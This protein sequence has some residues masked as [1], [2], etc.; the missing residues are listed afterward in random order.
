MVVLYKRPEHDLTKPTGDGGKLS[1]G[2]SPHRAT[3]QSECGVPS[4]PSKVSDEALTVICDKNGLADLLSDAGRA[5][6]IL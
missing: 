4:S 5:V 3:H 1:F 6:N 2:R